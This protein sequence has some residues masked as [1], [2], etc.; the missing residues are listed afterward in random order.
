M[1]DS[2][3]AFLSTLNEL[4][5]EAVAVEGAQAAQQLQVIHHH[6]VIIDVA[7]HPAEALTLVQHVRDQHPQTRRVALVDTAAQQQAAIDAGA[8]RAVLKGLPGE[9]LRAVLFAALQTG[10][11]TPIGLQPRS[12]Y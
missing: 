8:D 1:R 9:W 7:P 5:C 6:L 2:L 12:S 10:A 4:D 3:L 11:P